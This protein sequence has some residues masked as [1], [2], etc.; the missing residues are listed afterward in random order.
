VAARKDDEAV[1]SNL[2]QTLYDRY[3]V[4]EE[5]VRLELLGLLDICSLLALLAVVPLQQP[6]LEL[7][8]T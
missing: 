5:A 8:E 6:A 3:D 4:H 1:R 7:V 2:H